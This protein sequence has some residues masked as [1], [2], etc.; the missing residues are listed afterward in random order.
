[1]KQGSNSSKR[2]P[3]LTIAIPAYNVEAYIEACLL[4]LTGINQPIEVLVVD[5]G[6]SDQTTA[7]AL[8]IAKKHPYMTVMMKENGG[9]GSTI[10]TALSVAKGK[11]FK[12]LDGDDYFDKKSLS[13]LVEFL[14][15]ADT[16]IVLTDYIEYYMESST[17]KE[18]TNYNSLSQGKIYDINN[19]DPFLEHGPLL[20]TTTFKTSLF[21]DDPFLIDERCFYV[22]M[23]YNFF[24]YERAKNVA[25]LPLPLY[26]YRLE[27]QGQSMQ[28][29]SLIK[30]HAHHEKVCL[31]LAS[32]LSLMPDTTPKYA[33]LLRCIV[34]P[35]CRSHY[36]I[37]IEYIKSRR[38]FNMFDK[39]LK[40]YPAIY[41]SPLVSGKIISIHRIGGG[42]TIACDAL[43]RKFGR[44]LKRFE[45]E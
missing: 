9:H 15:T 36:Q 12:L 34:A 22:D 14:A 21:T 29:S 17:Q 6:S 19:S 40:Q 26:F 3:V 23:E 5:D 13:L 8:K 20:A 7:I 32:E 38:L 37:I 33:Y 44:V 10:N 35:L 1:M 39:K 30:N 2:T 24:I 31:R 45:T 25:Y 27:R 4:S 11:Y 16:D 42:I 43:L 18:I 28:K 41:H